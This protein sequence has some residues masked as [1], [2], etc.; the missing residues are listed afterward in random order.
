MLR[1]RRCR[2]KGEC[3]ETKGLKSHAML[4]LENSGTCFALCKGSNEEV[5]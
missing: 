3:L 2:L 5:R 1:E 4:S